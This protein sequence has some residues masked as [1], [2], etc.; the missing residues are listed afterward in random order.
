M[1]RPR[2]EDAPAADSGPA[3]GGDRRSV[4]LLAALAAVAAVALA[5][6]L[7]VLPRVGS[8]TVAGRG[9]AATIRPADLCPAV[10]QDDVAALTTCLVADLERTWSARTGEAIG[11]RVE[12]D[13]PPERVHHTCRAFLA[14]GTAFYCPSDVRAY[15]TRAS[16]SG[17]RAEFG[18]RLPYGLATVVAH[19]AGHRV[20]HV[21][22]E[23]ALEGEGDAASRRVEQQADCLTGV[24][25]TDV[26]RRGR[27]EPTAFRAVYAREMVLVSAVR[28][29]PGSGLEGYDEVATHGS[30]AQRLAAFD[31][32]AAPG[33][34]PAGACSLRRR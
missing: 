6:G 33:A 4:R 28:P 17:L 8:G 14:L 5:V 32:G 31:R 34:E 10:R 26:A 13:P 21:V 1:T 23:P 29:P 15:V 11:L 22:D 2:P 24:W 27:V 16:V 30:P 25:A 19:E 12:V 7:A 18:E 3:P 20:Q 9:M